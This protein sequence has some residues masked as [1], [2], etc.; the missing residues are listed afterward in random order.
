MTLV[1]KKVYPELPLTAISTRWSKPGTFRKIGRTIFLSMVGVGVAGNEYHSHMKVTEQAKAVSELKGELLKS[2]T[3][4]TRLL[5][6]IDRTAIIKKV[7]PSTV[8]IAGEAESLNFFTGQ[9]EKVSTTASGVIIK[10]KNEKRYILTNGHVLEKKED[11]SLVKSYKIKRYNGNDREPPIE[12]DGTVHVLADGKEAYSPPE[13]HDLA[14]FDIPEDVDLPGD[15]GVPI[16]KDIPDIGETVIAI[17]NPYGFRDSISIGTVS[18]NNRDF[19]INQNT[20]IQTD[21]AINPGNSGGAL[22]DSNGMLIG[23]NSLVI[24]PGVGGA[25]RGDCIVNQLE[26]WQIEL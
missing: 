1:I 7:C 20:Y 5:S 10:D 4:I 11:G 18:N 12:F 8:M 13:E 19:K 3:E 14:L 23:I 17:G 21:T 25:V 6:Q 22:V 24:A 9:I 16:R 26:D 15:L 2:Q